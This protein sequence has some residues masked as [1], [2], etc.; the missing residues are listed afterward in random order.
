[1]KKSLVIAVLALA[2]AGMASAQQVKVGTG[3]AKGTYKA[4]FNNITERCGNEMALVE[5]PSDGSLTN[6]DRLSNKEIGAAFLQ[7][8]ALF[9]SAQ[10][11][12]LGNI[13]TLAAFNKE[14][15]HV[16]VMVNSGLKTS[17]NMVGMGKQ[18]IVFKSVEDLAGYNVA[19]AGGSL[20][21]AQYIKQY[22]QVNYT[23]VP[24]ASNEEAVKQLKAGQVQAAILV[25]GKPFT[26]VRELGS[27]YRLVGFKPQT[28]ELLKTT[29][30]KDVLSYPKLSATPVDTLATEAL[31]V[32][33][34]V[35]TPERVAALASF[36]QCIYNNVNYWRD[37]DG[38]HPAWEQVFPENK[39]R[40]AYYDLPVVQSGKKK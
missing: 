3:G 21:T 34:T 30:V 6:L 17:G 25:G 1:M 39:G 16:I 22:G 15:V 14:S 31:L 27:E 4:L 10:G 2:M 19:A 8:D 32:V 35:N 18:D 37:A 36:R 13:K 23:V 24:V 40:W 26:L 20:I 11:R 12:D 7:T 9:A 28:T 33:R 38:A 5:V 29:Y